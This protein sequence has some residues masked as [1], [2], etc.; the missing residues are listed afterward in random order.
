M[1]VIGVLL[2]LLSKTGLLAHMIIS[3]LGNIVLIVY[4]IV[5]KKSI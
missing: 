3:V 5:S 4:T 2:F 1:L